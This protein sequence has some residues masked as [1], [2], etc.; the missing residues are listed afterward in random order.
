MTYKDIIQLL[1]D[2]APVISAFM[3]LV[4][5]VRWTRLTVR[6]LC[7]RYVALEARQHI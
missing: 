2:L 7:G 1:K 5:I 6:L 4:V 3:P